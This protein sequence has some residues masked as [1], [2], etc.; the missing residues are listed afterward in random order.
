[1]CGWE[2]SELERFTRETSADFQRVSA[3]R[4]R[5]RCVWNVYIL[6]NWRAQPRGVGSFLSDVDVY[7]RRPLDA[8]GNL[9][10][11]NREPVKYLIG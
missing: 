5:R 1:M 3:A 10:F 4:R 7:R 8:I 9:V 2:R 11:K 6:L